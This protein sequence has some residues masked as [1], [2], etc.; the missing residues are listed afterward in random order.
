VLCAGPAAQ[1]VAFK[2]FGG[3]VNL[4][5][6]GAR[7]A[8]ALTVVAARKVLPAS[9]LICK[10]IVLSR[11]QFYKKLHALCFLLSLWSLCCVVWP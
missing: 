11:L 6:I 10:N 3:I 5:P 1:L 9:F 8:L 4:D 7:H 2:C